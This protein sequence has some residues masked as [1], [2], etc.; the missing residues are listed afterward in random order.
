MMKINSCIGWRSRG[1][2]LAQAQATSARLTATRKENGSERPRR[3]SNSTM[4]RTMEKT[5]CSPAE[6]ICILRAEKSQ[7]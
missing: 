7:Q 2:L 4:K 1:M 3:T 5:S 6:R